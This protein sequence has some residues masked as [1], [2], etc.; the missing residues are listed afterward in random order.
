MLGAIAPVMSIHLSANCAQDPAPS[1]TLLL[2]TAARRRTAWY[3]GS[4]SL[5]VVQLLSAAGSSAG[6]RG[7]S[8]SGRASA[9][10]YL[11]QAEQSGYDVPRRFA[12]TV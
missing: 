8:R 1:C 3:A 9:P 12:I 11:G 5:C 6:Q 2:A 10:L 7:S 4:P